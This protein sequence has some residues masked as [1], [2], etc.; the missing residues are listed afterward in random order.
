M[1][2]FVYHAVTHA[3]TPPTCRLPVGHT[4]GKGDGFISYV[5]HWRYGSNATNG[6]F[7]ALGKSQVTPQDFLRD[8][9]VMYNS[10]GVERLRQ[11][12]V[13]VYANYLWKDWAESVAHEKLGGISTNM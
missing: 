5:A 8:L 10:N 2:Q 7:G 3:S 4:H 1:S 9:M 12:P 6:A 11:H 13:G